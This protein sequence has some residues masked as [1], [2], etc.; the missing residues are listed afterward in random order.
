M[1]T[2]MPTRSYLRR[3]R[4]ALAIDWRV[5]HWIVVTMCALIVSYSSDAWTR[6]I[7]A[8]APAARHSSI[9]CAASDAACVIAA[10]NVASLD[11][12]PLGNSRSSDPNDLWFDLD[13]EEDEDGQDN[14]G[15]ASADRS[16]ADALG[17][18]RPAAAHE[19]SITPPGPT[20]AT[21]FLTESVRRM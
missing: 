9:A 20:A 12:Q 5:A 2:R 21:L 4:R 14:S 6:P 18:R 1:E 17:L 15:P 16:L 3:R 10:A 11:S 7:D 8:A 13:E 19:G